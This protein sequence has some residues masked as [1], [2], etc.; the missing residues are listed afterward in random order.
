[1]PQSPLQVVLR[2]LGR[3][4]SIGYYYLLGHAPILPLPFLSCVVLTMP[5]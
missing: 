2:L 3:L 5:L 4:L 1:M